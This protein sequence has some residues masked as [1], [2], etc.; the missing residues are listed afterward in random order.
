VDAAGLG[1]L[2]G[3]KLAPQLRQH[4]HEENMLLTVLG[5]TALAGVVAAWESNLFAAV[6]LSLV[7]AFAAAAGKLAFDS[8]VQR[9]APDA[10]YG[11]SF[12]R[13]EARFQLTW[14]VGAFIPVVVPLPAWVGYTIVALAAGFATV[15]YVLG[16]RAQHEAAAEGG[17][18][19]EVAAVAPHDRTAVFE[20]SPAGEDEPSDSETSGSPDVTTVMQS[21][22]GDRTLVYGASQ[23]EP[24]ESAALPGGA[25]QP[26]EAE[27]P[28]APVP[29]RDQAASPSWPSWAD[30]PVKPVVS[31]VEGVE[32]DPDVAKRSRR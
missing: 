25:E 2:V 8:L 18:Q 1:A 13:F 19:P 24:A 4:V 28:E 32:I 29:E 9:D 14:V 16:V 11:R 3:A 23:A 7:V 10:N 30:A 17:A 22:D 6:L 27:Q 5:L 21:G 31:S 15:S 26:G 20:Q 12:A